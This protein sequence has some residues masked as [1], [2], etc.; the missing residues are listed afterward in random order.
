MKYLMIIT[1]VIALLAIVLVGYLYLNPG[2]LTAYSAN[3][4]AGNQITS[5]E[6]KEI[7][8][9]LKKMQDELSTLRDLLSRQSLFTQKLQEDNFADKAKISNIEKRLQ[10][11]NASGSPSGLNTSDLSYQKFSPELFKDPE[12]AKVF[13]DQVNQAI[14]TID[15]QNRDAQMQRMAD[16]AQQAMKSRID[17]FAKAQNLTE[18]QQQ[19]LNKIIADRTAKMTALLTQLRNQ[20][21][22]QDEYTAQRTAIINEANEKLKSL[23]PPDQMTEFQK[24]DNQSN[25]GTGFGGRGGRNNPGQ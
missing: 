12:F 21:I 2:F 13:T 19:Q 22:Q 20:Q 3:E 15:K 4:P 7:N 18:S 16:R 25:R 6:A 10:G 9:H 17:D 8:T 5:S 11:A 23:L 24:I 1:A 14:Q